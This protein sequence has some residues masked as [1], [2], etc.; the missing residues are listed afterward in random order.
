MNERLMREGC[1][2]DDRMMC[3]L[4][5]VVQM[6]GWWWWWWCHSFKCAALL[7]P[8]PG[9]VLLLVC[10]DSV[11]NTADQNSGQTRPFTPS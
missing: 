6:E 7:N 4:R 10:R 9:P 11:P 1:N 2:G 8:H 3:I 5:D